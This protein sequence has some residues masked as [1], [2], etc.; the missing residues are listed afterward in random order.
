VILKV[1]QI[2]KQFIQKDSIKMFL[3]NSKN[4]VEKDGLTEIK[5]VYE[6]KSNINSTNSVNKVN[7]LEK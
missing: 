7:L 2:Y 4:D 3:Q 5:E 1:E 6:T